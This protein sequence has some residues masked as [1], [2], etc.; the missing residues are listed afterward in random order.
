MTETWQQHA[1]CVG[2]T[3]RRNEDGTV[4]DIFFD[5]YESDPQVR[6]QVKELCSLCPSRRPCKYFGETNKLSGVFGGEYLDRG[7]SIEDKFE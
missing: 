1:L 7:A 6:E 3:S 2:M 5:T 4:T